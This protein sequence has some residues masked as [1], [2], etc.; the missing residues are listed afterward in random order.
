[1][2]VSE[3]SVRYRGST[4]LDQNDDDDGR[5][6][7]AID[8]ES[9]SIDLLTTYTLKAIT[10]IALPVTTSVGG[11]TFS[12]ATS[13]FASLTAKLEAAVT[14]GSFSTLLQTVSV[15]LGATIT[16]AADV[17]EVVSSNPIINIEESIVIQAAE[18]M[19]TRQIVVMAVSSFIG[20]WILLNWMYLKILDLEDSMQFHPQ[21][22]KGTEFKL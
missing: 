1:M 11:T 8:I 2:G 5:R 12:N 18:E 9:E 6:L 4:V 20:L 22:A 14:D 10:E 15:E 16:V 3:N 17:T 13:L 7:L 21:Y 19:N